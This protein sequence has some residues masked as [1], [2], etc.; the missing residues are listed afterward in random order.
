MKEDDGRKGCPACGNKEF[1]HLVIER[2]WAF[3]VKDVG[4]SDVVPGVMTEQFCTKEL[5]CDAC[6]W[7]GWLDEYW[8]EREGIPTISDKSIQE[9]L[10][11]E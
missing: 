7:H 5:I 10:D 8:L 6:S 11:N 1:F 4:V 9:G 3:K 2:Q